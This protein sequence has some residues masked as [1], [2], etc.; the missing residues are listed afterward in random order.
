MGNIGSHSLWSTQ[1]AIAVLSEYIRVSQLSQ[2]SVKAYLAL[3]KFA[4]PTVLASETF[5]EGMYSAIDTIVN[6]HEFDSSIEDDEGNVTEYTEEEIAEMRKQKKESM[7]AAF[8]KE[9]AN[10]VLKKEHV[11]GALTIFTEMLTEDTDKDRNDVIDKDEMTQLGADAVYLIEKLKRDHAGWIRDSTINP[12]VLK[13]EEVAGTPTE[14]TGGNGGETTT[15][16]GNGE[17]RGEQQTQ[18]STETNVKGKRPWW[19]VPGLVVIGVGVL[20]MSQQ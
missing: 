4:Q 17:T 1:G 15:T 7:Q 16:S 11:K 3:L 9:R 5:L 12:Y 6:E 14:T 19:L 2:H 20:A 8:D 18:T 10:I 13:I